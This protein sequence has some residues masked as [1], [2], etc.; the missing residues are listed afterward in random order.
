M[1]LGEE[2][3][4]ARRDAV[5]NC[6]YSRLRRF[7][8]WWPVNAFIRPSGVWYGASHRP[9]GFGYIPQRCPPKRHPEH[10][11]QPDRRTTR[12]CRKSVAGEVRR[13]VRS[14]EH[15]SELQSLMRISYAVFCLKK[16]RTTSTHIQYP[17]K[18]YSIEPTPICH[19]LQTH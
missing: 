19:T 7:T 10:Q 13:F 16:N 15:T 6:S 3:Q 14:E 11:R 2:W 18:N 9:G 17:P 1:E 4:A 5:P 8:A 12:G